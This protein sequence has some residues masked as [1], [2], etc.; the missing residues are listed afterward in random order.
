MTDKNSE[1]KKSIRSIAHAYESSHRECH[2]YEEW[3]EEQWD[4][5]ELAEKTALEVANKYQEMLCTA[6]GIIQ[7]YRTLLSDGSIPYE[8][9]EEISIKLFGEYF[10]RPGEKSDE[11]EGL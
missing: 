9:T 11:C 10:E 4:R 2:N 7:Y 3:G 5:V 8:T 6:I 1:L